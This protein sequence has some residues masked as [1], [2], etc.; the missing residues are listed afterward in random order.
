MTTHWPLK[1][2]WE[3]I[4]ACAVAC[5]VRTGSCLIRDGR[6]IGQTI[7]HRIDRTS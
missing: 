2:A 7:H 5:P 4:D 1:R 3:R 6:I